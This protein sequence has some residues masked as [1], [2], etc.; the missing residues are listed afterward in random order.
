MVMVVVVRCGGGGGG[1]GDQWWWKVGCFN[2]PHSA[3]RA[4]AYS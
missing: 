1:G 2:M 3:T 4:W